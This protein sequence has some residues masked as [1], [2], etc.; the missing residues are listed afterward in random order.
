MV[1]VNLRKYMVFRNTY[2]F[3]RIHLSENRADD[4]ELSGS[5]KDNID[6]RQA[7]SPLMTLSLTSTQNG[8]G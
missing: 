5:R 1:G 8:C 2:A 3:Q 4:Q 7:L 6:V